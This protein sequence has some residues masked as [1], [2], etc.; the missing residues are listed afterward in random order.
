MDFVCLVRQNYKAQSEKKMRK[1]IDLHVNI[2]RQAVL[3]VF[4]RNYKKN[5]QDLL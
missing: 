4:V 2:F 5:K 3:I 1:N